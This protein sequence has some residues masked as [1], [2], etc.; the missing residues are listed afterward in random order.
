MKDTRKVV[1]IVIFFIVFSIV[2]GYAAGYLVYKEY[3][4]KTAI[5]EREAKEKFEKLELSL[6]SLYGAL[7]NTMD[8]NKIERKKALAV[9]EDIR[10]GIG[11]W[12]KDQASI[13]AELKDTIKQLKVGKL[14]RMVENLQDDI[15]KFKMT[16]QDLDIKVD[17][18]TRGE[19]AGLD[20][21]DLG[22]I[23]V[24]K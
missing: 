2:A 17:E 23:S 13:I 10:E 7:E 20:N 24:K 8:E 21:V 11:E 5:L 16:V 18:V 19:G 6:K 4:K 3:K 15:D 12:K 9:V 22:R 14:T 1:T